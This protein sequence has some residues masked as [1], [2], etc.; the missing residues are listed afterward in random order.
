MNK[1][2]FN[3]KLLIGA[4]CVVAGLNIWLCLVLRKEQGRELAISEELADVKEQR[5]YYR[6]SFRQVLETDAAARDSTGRLGLY[7]K[8]T[9]CGECN[10][11]TLAFARKYFAGER[12]AVYV[13]SLHESRFA[14][15]GLD[16]SEVYFTRGAA[17]FHSNVN[18]FFLETTAGRLLK[19]SHESRFADASD[20]YFKQLKQLLKH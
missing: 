20:I 17:F 10:T 12:L 19:F 7:L 9:G 6:S 3:R 18:F 16:P 15:L 14:E 2:S 5:D 11:Q 8:V 4:I 1:I 13:D